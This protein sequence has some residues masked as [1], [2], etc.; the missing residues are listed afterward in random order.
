[1]LNP[2][3][4]YVSGTVGKSKSAHEPAYTKRRNL[5]NSLTATPRKEGSWGS[6]GALVVEEG[7]SERLPNNF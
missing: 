2:E 6:A 7:A 4:G 5:K 3:T 1:S